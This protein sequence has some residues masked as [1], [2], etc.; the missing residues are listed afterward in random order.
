MVV[1]APPPAKWG[2][3]ALGLA[4]PAGIPAFA[5]TPPP[6]QFVPPPLAVAMAG[7][8]AAMAAA[9]AAAMPQ[10]AGGGAMV[11][12][13]PLQVSVS[14]AVQSWTRHT[15]GKDTWYSNDSNP[16]EVSWDLPRGAIVH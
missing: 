6:P 10:H 8:A 16:Q 12:V 4:P 2:L 14:S 3:A 7:T 1:Y 11:T 9:G 15:D 13:S 5:F